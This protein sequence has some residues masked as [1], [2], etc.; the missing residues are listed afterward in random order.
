MGL[1][2][3]RAGAGAKYSLPD[4]LLDVQPRAAPTTDF[5]SSSVQGY[6]GYVDTLNQRDQLSS[7]SGGA[8]SYPAPGGADQTGRQTGSGDDGM[9]N[10]AR[11]QLLKTKRQY[12]TLLE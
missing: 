4:Q 5:G 12:E 10:G 3:D 11:G 6:D 2:A 8:P 9:V 1:G 7:L